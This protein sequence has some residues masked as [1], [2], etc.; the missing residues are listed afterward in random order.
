MKFNKNISIFM[1]D[2]E[3]KQNIQLGNFCF[4]EYNIPRAE[5]DYFLTI[6]CWL[7]CNA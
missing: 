2:W 7:S 3:E 4:E 1:N 5:E 6:N